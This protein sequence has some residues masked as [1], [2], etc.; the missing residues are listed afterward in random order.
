MVDMSQEINNGGHVTDV[1]NGGNPGNNNPTPAT[2]MS[3]GMD[4]N[5]PLFLNPADIS[6]VN[7]ISFQLLVIENY[8]VW[9]RSI[10]LALLGRNK[11]GLV[12]GSCTKDGVSPELRNQWE[13]VNAVV[14][15]WL[16][17]SVS[18][19]LLGG[20][21]FASTAQSVWN[22]LKE[23]F[24][25]M[26]GSRT[27]SLHKEIATLQQGTDSVS[28]YFTKLKNLWDEFEALVPSPGCNCEKSRGFIDHVNRQKL[29][30]FLMGL[31]ESYGQARSQILLMSPIPGVNQAYA[32]VVS[33]ECQR[34]ASNSNNMG[35]NSISMSGVDPLAMYSKSGG[36][37]SAQVP[38]KFKKSFGIVCEFCRCK[39]HT[40]D[41]CY[42]LIGYP[43]EF[44]SKRKA[45]NGAG[46]TAYMVVNES[47]NTRR[48]AYDGVSDSST[49]FNYGFNTN[50]PGTNG[51]SFAGNNEEDECAKHLQG[52]TFTKEQYSQILQML[53]QNKGTA[54]TGNAAQAHGV[55]AHEV[56]TNAA[57][58]L[59]WQGEGDW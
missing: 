1:S 53:K 47:S 15:S 36:S 34:F 48:E 49:S 58:A 32:M 13:R 37:T 3:Q 45:V 8:A 43:P 28:V 56:Q 26:D 7:L 19:S 38:N 27:F 5:H 46:N 35:M 11:I 59:H 30:Q 6:G 44:K 4:Y 10:R 50:V 41:Q 40:K 55:Q 57:G 33:D 23:K 22:D 51:K 2:S 52:C 54:N 20:V 21:A 18:K 16:L 31:N 42:K 25:R 9:S 14:L 12:D 29:Y 24:D 17:N 39:G